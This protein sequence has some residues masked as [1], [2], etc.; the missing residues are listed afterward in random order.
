MSLTEMI[1]ISFRRDA[2]TPSR[3]YRNV[4]PDEIN[5]CIQEGAG[6]VRRVRRRTARRE[7]AERNARRSAREHRRSR[8]HGPGGE[9]RVFCAVAEGAEVIR[10]APMFPA[11]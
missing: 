3:Y 8:R 1:R 11:A 7:Y 9:P 6:R 5:G 10:E 2:G 4:W